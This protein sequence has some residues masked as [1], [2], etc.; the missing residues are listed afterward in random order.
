M[1]GLKE[2]KCEPCSGETATGVSDSEAAELQAQVSHWRMVSHRGG[3]HLEREFAFD[4]FAEALEFTRKVGTLAEQENHHPSLLTEWGRVRV[5]WWTHK[6]HGLHRNDFIMASKT[7]DL[8]G[9]D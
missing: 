6:I 9:V 3:K 4:D 1:S 2:M 8:Y 7:D 5:K